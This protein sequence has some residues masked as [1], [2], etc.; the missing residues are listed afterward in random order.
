MTVDQLN[1]L[2]LFSKVRFTDKTA[3]TGTEV[4]VEAVII[5]IR[6]NEARLYD[7][8]M[9]WLS[10]YKPADRLTLV[11]SFNPGS[12]PAPTNFLTMP[13]Y[14]IV[15]YKGAEC[16]LIGKEIVQNTF[17]PEGGHDIE[18]A[19]IWFYADEILLTAIPAAEITFV[20][21]PSIVSVVGPGVINPDIIP[22]PTPDIIPTPEP[23]MSTKKLLIIGGIGLA[24]YFL[25]R[26]KHA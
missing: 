12:P 14:S 8:T 23:G 10:S 1:A 7:A 3:V 5:K 9:G 24:I 21:L 11:E 22:T 2:P 17:F 19:T 18:N 4:T 20:E 6:N 13:L 15:S 25:A 26:D 16:F